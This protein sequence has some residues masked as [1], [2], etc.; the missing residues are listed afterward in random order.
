[1]Q[2]CT[3][4]DLNLASRTCFYQ[5]R[6]KRNA[7][8]SHSQFTLP[9]TVA[10]ESTQTGQ[11]MSNVRRGKAML[12]WCKLCTINK[13]LVPQNSNKRPMLN[14][15]PQHWHPCCYWYQCWLC[16]I[17]DLH[18]GRSFTTP[19]ITC[20]HMHVPQQPGSLG[21]LLAGGPQH[22]EQTRQSVVHHQCMYILNNLYVC[23]CMPASDQMVLYIYR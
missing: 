2:V 5:Q 3:Q 23:I 13:F 22:G 4:Y 10:Q 11:F 17:K 6:S 12:W 7:P 1:M 16:E 15:S 19:D 18:W 20:T 14:T 8:K 21:S 9:L